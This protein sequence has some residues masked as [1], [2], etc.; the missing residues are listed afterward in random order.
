[1]F[2]KKYIRVISSDRWRRLKAAV[3]KRRGNRCECCG[4]VSLPLDLHHKHY[5]TL[6]RERHRDVELLCHKCHDVADA[7]RK[8]Q[9]A[10]EIAWLRICDG[11]PTERDFQ[12]VEEGRHGR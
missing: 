7:K 6:G 5:E 2:S 1:M 8:R 4:V 12:L 10:V 9:R 11:H 3:S